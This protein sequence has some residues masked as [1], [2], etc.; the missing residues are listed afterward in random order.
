MARTTK[1]QASRQKTAHV[2]SSESTTKVNIDDRVYCPTHNIAFKFFCIVRLYTAAKATIPDCDEVYNYWEPAHYLQY[3]NGLQT[4][5]YSP[6]Y[7][8]RSWAYVGLHA[9]LGRAMTLLASNKVGVYLIGGD[10]CDAHINISIKIQVFY[11]MRFAMA[12]MCAACEATFYTAVVEHFNRR[13]AR[14]LL[15]ALL[16]NAGMAQAASAFLPSTFAMYTSATLCLAVGAIWGWPFSG[17]IGIPF[18]FEELFISGNQRVVLQRSDK[19][20]ANKSASDLSPADPLSRQQWMPQRWLHFTKCIVVAFFTVLLPLIIIDSIFYRQ[21]VI[22]PWNIVRYNVLGGAD[23]GPDLYGT[24]PWWFY[25]ANG[26]I[27]FNLLW[28]LALGS[29]PLLIFNTLMGGKSLQVSHPGTTSSIIMSTIRLMPMYIW[30]LIFTMQPHKEERFLYPI[31]PLI[32]FNACVALCLIRH[33]ADYVSTNLQH[34]SAYR[35]RLLSCC[36][37]ALIVI[38]SGISILRFHGIY[39]FYY[40]P[41]SVY[42]YLSNVAA[43]AHFN[44]SNTTLSVCVGKEWFRFPSSYLLPPNS[45]LY[46]LRSNFRGLLP[47]YFAESTSLQHQLTSLSGQQVKRLDGWRPGTSTVPTSMN[48]LNQ[49]ELDRYVDADQCNYL[50]DV[51]FPHRYNSLSH[52]RVKSEDPHEPRYNIHPEWKEVHCEPYLD[53]PHTWLVSNGEEGD[54]RYWGRY[55][56]LERKSKS[57]SNVLEQSSNK[58]KES[59]TTINHDDL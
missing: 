22:V 3:G 4:W 35:N 48:D 7:A 32:C 20:D 10:N 17:A 5:E 45:R 47:K 13:V 46:F 58:A 36:T 56:L 50:I 11:A 33:L 34:L 53:A 16:F 57:N 54:G 39:S 31:Y 18:I 1:R 26:L 59:A 49:E 41:I 12:I 30:L 8:I 29:L 38:T 55:C 21:W 14:Y 28:L 19:H 2:D 23:R 51:D 42:S 44:S 24:E 40:A 43:P 25:I 37:M 15:L 52:S 27:N 6:E 9:L